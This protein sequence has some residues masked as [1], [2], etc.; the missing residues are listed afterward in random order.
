M[1]VLENCA[2][3]CFVFFVLSRE[4]TNLW[5]EHGFHV[6]VGTSLKLYKISIKSNPLMSDR[7]KKQ[8]YS[9][10][11]LKSTYLCNDEKGNMY[12]I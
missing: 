6:K 7:H 5:C 1:R 8:S 11:F 4:P 10:S 3:Y 12:L 9:P 2:R